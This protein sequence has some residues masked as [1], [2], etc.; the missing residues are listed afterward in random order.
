MD[1]IGSKKKSKG[2]KGTFDYSSNEEEV[3]AFDD[4]SDD[5]DDDDMDDKIYGSDIEEGDLE[6]EEIEEE[7]D[8]NQNNWGSRKSAYYSG[9]Y[10][11]FFKI[12]KVRDIQNYRF[13][14]YF[15]PFIQVK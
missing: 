1:K 9:I 2:Q 4:T 7:N 3:L 12:F 6:E 13:Q 10:E 11:L 5:D 8:D 14:I 15:K